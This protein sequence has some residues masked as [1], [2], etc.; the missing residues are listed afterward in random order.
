MNDLYSKYGREDLLIA[1]QIAEL[2]QKLSDTDYKALKHM[3]GYYTDEQWEQIK[4]ER[5]AL[6]EQ[7]NELENQL[8][9]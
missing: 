9:N 1:E 7:I 3:E 6:R 4:A 2:K 8:E 5:K